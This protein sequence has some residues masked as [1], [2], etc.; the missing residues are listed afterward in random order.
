MAGDI[1]PRRVDTSENLADMM[2]KALEN[3]VL[4]RL[5]PSAKGKGEPPEFP[6]KPKD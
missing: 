5:V 4:Q 1:D 3:N 2:T 6:P